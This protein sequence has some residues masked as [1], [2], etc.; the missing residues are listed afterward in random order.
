[1]TKNKQ[2][3]RAFGI[4][5]NTDKDKFWDNLIPILEWANDKKIEPYITTRIKDNLPKGF[6]KKVNIINSAKDFMKIDFLVTLGWR[7]NNLI[8]S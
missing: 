2:T 5:G 3:P 6:D 8:S 1:M 4:W 7:W